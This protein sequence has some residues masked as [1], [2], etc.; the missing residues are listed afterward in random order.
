MSRVAL[1]G[2]LRRIDTF[3]RNAGSCR[4][5]A[6]AYS[7][8]EVATCATI[9]FGNPHAIAVA[10]AHSVASQPPPATAAAS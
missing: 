9:E 10:T 6:I 1:I 2:T 4:S 7:S 5:R 3:A 8:R